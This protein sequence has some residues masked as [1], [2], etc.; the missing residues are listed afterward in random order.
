M[1]DLQQLTKLKQTTHACRLP[2]Y[3]GLVRISQ[4]NIIK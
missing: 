2:I 3:W 4:L 1:A